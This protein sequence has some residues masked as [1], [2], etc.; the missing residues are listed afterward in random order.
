MT[1][2]LGLAATQASGLREMF[3]TMCKPFHPGN[4]A[5][6]GLLSAL[7]ARSNFTSSIQAIEAPPK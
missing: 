3:G 2:A 1:W 4:A 5:R 6:N 7:L